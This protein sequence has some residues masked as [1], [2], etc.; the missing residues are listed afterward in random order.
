MHAPFS[1]G[2]VMHAFKTFDGGGVIVIVG[3]GEA[4]VSG[5]MQGRAQLSGQS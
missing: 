2:R 3:C 5:Q 1:L 4:V